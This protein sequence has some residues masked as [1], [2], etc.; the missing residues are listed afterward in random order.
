MAPPPTFLCGQSPTPPP[1]NP[2]PRTRDLGAGNT[3]QR[4]LAAPWGQQRTSV[5]RF[6]GSLRAA[7]AQRGL[8][9]RRATQPMGNMVPLGTM[10]LTWLP[11]RLNGATRVRPFSATSST[12]GCGD[13]SGGGRRAGSVRTV[14]AT[15]FHRLRGP[16]LRSSFHAGPPCGYAPWRVPALPFLKAMLSF[17]EKEPTV[18]PDSIWLRPSWGRGQPIKEGLWSQVSGQSRVGL[19]EGLGKVIF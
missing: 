14:I 16:L 10:F 12:K 2:P 19:E 8:K 9:G 13:V 3:N 6:S 18:A 1:L 5:P 17:S 15:R 7:H 4:Q 11:L